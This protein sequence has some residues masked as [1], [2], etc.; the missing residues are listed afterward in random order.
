MKENFID[1]LKNIAPDILVA[2]IIIVIGIILSRLLVRIFNRVLSKSHVEP[3]AYKFLGAILKVVLYILTFIIALSMLGVD[4]TSLVALLSVVGLAVSLSVQNSLSNL[5]GG[6]MILFSKPFVIGDFVEVDG[7]SGTVASVSILQTSLTTPDNKVIYIPN[8]QI[9]AG[10]IT[11]FSAQNKRRLDL[12]F[13][14]SYNDDFENAKK[15]ISD[16]IAANSEHIINDPPPFVRVGA[17]SA[18]SVDIICRVWVKPDFYWNLNFDLIE[19]VK[20]AFDKAGISIPFNQ[21][22]VHID[23]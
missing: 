2:V 22:D 16:V 23:K 17:L 5:A 7:M 10:K 3:T 9:S 1:F 6:I 20:T 4:M 19:G 15:I 12:T 13:S 18:H 11:N 21:L 14:I 8:G